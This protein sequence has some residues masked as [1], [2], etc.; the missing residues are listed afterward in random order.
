[1][2]TTYDWYIFKMDVDN[3]VSANVNSIPDDAV[4][5][6]E[7]T[8][9][10]VMSCMAIDEYGF[11]TV[12]G[13]SDAPTFYNCEEVGCAERNALWGRMHFKLTWEVNEGN[14]LQTFEYFNSRFT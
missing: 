10:E 13:Y 5:F 11:I 8:G 1:M 12:G 3:M 2:D 9:D 4:Y 14:N 6:G 7:K